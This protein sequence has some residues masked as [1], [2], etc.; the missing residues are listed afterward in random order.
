MKNAIFL[1]SQGLSRTCLLIVSIFSSSVSV[2]VSKKR[3][4]HLSMSWWRSDIL[5]WMTFLA[6]TFL[7][8][9]LAIRP[10]KSARNL[11][12]YIFH[13]M[14]GVRRLERLIKGQN[15][16]M[17][18]AA[19]AQ[20]KI[21]PRTSAT[22]SVVGR[23]SSLNDPKAAIVHKRAREQGM[24]ARVGQSLRGQAIIA[25]SRAS[26]SPLQGFQ[27]C[28]DVKDELV[29]VEIDQHLGSLRV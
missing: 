25:R 1:A 29:H 2:I 13:A 14:R 8:S 6:S 22:C 23:G 5:D 7:P 24:G 12:T 17:K 15:R 9:N 18:R 16:T 4:S 19:T 20:T 27:H 3:V 21:H 11:V 26:F 28:I 10:S